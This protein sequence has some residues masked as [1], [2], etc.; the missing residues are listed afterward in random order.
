MQALLHVET[1]TLDPARVN[2]LVA[3]LWNPAI[4]VEAQRMRID[5]LAAQIR[6]G[7]PTDCDSRCRFDASCTSR[8]RRASRST[9]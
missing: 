5:A 2:L 3:H 9:A 4:D 6:A 8:R 1:G 7:L